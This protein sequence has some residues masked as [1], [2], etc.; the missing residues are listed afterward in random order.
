[1]S[2]DFIRLKFIDKYGKTKYNEFVLSLYD[3]FPRRDT[4]FFWQE[5]L[6]NDLFKEL[7]IQLLDLD[8]VYKIFNY[9]PLHDIEL[10]H[11]NVP[12]V[13]GEN[14][15]EVYD[16]SLSRQLFPLANINAPRD[17]TRFTYPQNLNVYYCSTCRQI[18]EITISEIENME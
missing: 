4:L 7:N 14:Y 9:C 2:F 5:K 15:K 3:S 6:V 8:D 11:D 12:I 18:Q 17:L 16:Y 1:M 13:D 10:L